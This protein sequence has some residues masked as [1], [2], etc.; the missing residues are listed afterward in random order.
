MMN[1]ELRR[2]LIACALAVRERAYAPYSNYRV[3]AALLAGSG[4]IYDGVN[5]ENAAYPVGIC[6][7][8]TA[9]VKAV[10]EGERAFVAIVVATNNG[11]TPCGMCR[12]MLSEFGLDLTVITVDKDGALR[13][14]ALL[15]ELLPSAFVPGDLDNA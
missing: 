11:G 7:E 5:V 2:A 4:K 9:L 1:E 12:Q 15:S 10:S 14:E 13:G 8:R 3:G 6:A